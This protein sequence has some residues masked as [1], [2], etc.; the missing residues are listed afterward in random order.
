MFPTLS[1]LDAYAHSE[2][3]YSFLIPIDL[4]LVSARAVLQLSAQ[5][6][7]VFLDGLILAT[8]TGV[9][10]GPSFLYSTRIVAALKLLGPG[11]VV[12]RGSD[13]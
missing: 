1:A 8:R 7:G 11:T 2:H 13:I 5:L 10:A 6:Q 9:A 3:L 12:V 4:R